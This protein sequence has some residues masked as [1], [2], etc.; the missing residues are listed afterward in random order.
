LKEGALVVLRPV[1][2]RAFHALDV[3]V[4]LKQL[5]PMLRADFPG[6]SAGK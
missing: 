3:E 4:P 5:Q 1:S 2:A 6:T